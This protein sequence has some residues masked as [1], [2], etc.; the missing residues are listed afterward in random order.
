[1]YRLVIGAMPLPLPILYR[2]QQTIE[3]PKK[4]EDDAY[5]CSYPRSGNSFVRSMIAAYL[6]S[7]IGYDPSIVDGIVPD[8]HRISDWSETD[9]PRP[10]FMKSHLF[11]DKSYA[12][13]FYIIRDGRDVCVSYY[14]FLSRR[15]Q[16]HGSFSDFIKQMSNELVWP[17]S[18]HTHVSAWMKHA[19]RPGFHLMRYEELLADPV[20]ALLKIVGTMG[21]EV[22]RERGERAAERTSFENYQ[23]DLS[24]RRLSDTVSGKSGGWRDEFSDADYDVFMAKAGDTLRECGYSD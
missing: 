19:D 20:S 6:D 1:M 3:L 5:I 7:S 9:V 8:L 12:N 24:R 22:D 16:F 4:Y 13:A 15:A 10:R 17:S 23:N 2:Q 11:C 21:V 14:K 18:W